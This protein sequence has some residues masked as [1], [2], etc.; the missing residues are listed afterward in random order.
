MGII[1]KVSVPSLDFSKIATTA[2]NA[3]NGSFL[4]IDSI[5]TDYWGDE[6]N[7]VDIE[8]VAGYDDVYLVTENG[9]PLGF[10]T[11][12]NINNDVSEE[13]QDVA[14]IEE[15]ENTETTE[16]N[17][18]YQ[19]DNIT[20]YYES[21]N[22]RSI[23]YVNEDGSYS[24]EYFDD[25]DS[26]LWSRKV[27]SDANGKF[28]KLYKYSTDG[29]YNM[30]NVYDKVGSSVPV[31]AMKYNS[32]WQKISDIEYLENGNYY[33][34]M[35]YNE[36]ISKSLYDNNGNIISSDYIV[37]DKVVCT[38]KYENGN[39]S[40]RT[41]YFEDGSNSIS[42]YDS[43]GK[44]TSYIFKDST[45]NPMISLDDGN[46]WVNYNN[47]IYF[48][49]GF[50]NLACYP[51]SSFKAANDGSNR[52]YMITEINGT[53]YVTVTN[54]DGNNSG[55]IVGYYSV[56]EAKS[57]GILPTRLDSVPLY[58]QNDSYD[59]RFPD[60]DTIGRS[61]CG[62]CSMAMAISYLTGDSSITPVTLAQTYADGYKYNTYYGDGGMQY[63]FPPKVAAD[64]GLSCTTTSDIN[65]VV[66]A[67]QNG[68]VVVSSQGP[69]IFTSKGHIIT[70]A[71]LDSNGNI[72]VNNPSG[73]INSYS[74]SSVDASAARYWIISD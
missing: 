51:V 3:S 29:E 60:G 39:I 46:K 21:G 14:P 48:I 17:T 8:E 57:M 16:E 38:Y 69:G 53:K 36:G 23:K 6:N 10:T 33:E 30:I 54:Y 7:S 20:S 72:I 50:G 2:S 9:V 5:N 71:G 65:D 24:I 63:S 13:S 27:F 42:N 26:G 61:G 11:G 44:I 67:L 64:Y 31:S 43:S 73:S 15:V 1:K 52:Y 19:N 58:N 41:D 37:N 35:P 68:A 22:V 47:N 59:Y 25:N 62:F 12:D 56:D 28:E 74:P 55:E 40:S 70:L 32:S 4:S 18:S 34:T 49:N 66:T 45:G